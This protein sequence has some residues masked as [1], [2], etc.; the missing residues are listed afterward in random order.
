MAELYNIKPI[1]LK[2]AGINEKYIQEWICE[3]P[4]RL[5]L[6]DIEIDKRELT[7]PKGGR[8]DI[9]AK[10][11][12]S[13][14]YYEIE[15]MLGECDSDHGFR[16]LDYWARERLARPES[17]HIAVLVAENLQGRYKTLLETL[18]E[19]IPFIGIELKAYKVEKE[20]D[21]Q[22]YFAKC[23]V[24]VKRD[25]S[26]EIEGNGPVDE[27][28]WRDV[29]GDHYVEFIKNVAALC[30]EEISK[31]DLRFSA[32]KYISFMIDGKK[33][34]PIWY[35]KEGGYAYL[36]G[37]GTGTAD[38]PSELYLSIKERLDKEGI[39]HNWVQNSSYNPIAISIT[40]D[41]YN[42]PVLIEILKELYAFV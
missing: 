42:N 27:N 32:K 36:P 3:Q 1:T 7:Q 16:T 25:D 8:L 13:E 20:V 22:T 29:R 6:K 33:W 21:D 24:V 2:E 17:E 5:G 18:T 23:E 31:V 12:H 26:P 41:N 30:S 39:K 9:L 37:D 28:S 4:T 38:E 19:F 34:F 11:K 10:S 15:L 40:F 14:R 35:R